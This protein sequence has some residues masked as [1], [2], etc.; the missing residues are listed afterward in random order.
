MNLLQKRIERLA[1]EL[2]TDMGLNHSLVEFKVNEL[3]I[4]IDRGY[5]TSA[6]IYSLIKK[7][8]VA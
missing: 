6:E 5:N 4:C 3:M 2:F 1:F 7:A 8:Q